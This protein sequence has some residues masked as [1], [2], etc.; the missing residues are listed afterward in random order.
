MSALPGVLLLVVLTL[1]VAASADTLRVGECAFTVTPLA[2]D[3]FA[4]GL[5]RWMVEGNSRVAT[6][7]G[8]L[9]IETPEQGYA[10]VWYRQP[11]S[12]DLLIRF[13]ARVLPPR[14]ASNI[15]F[16]CYA[17]LPEGGGFFAPPRT[18]AYAEYHRINNYTMTFTGRREGVASAPGYLRLRKNPGFHLVDE[19]LEVKAEIETDYAI[20]LAKVGPLI[21]VF[22]NDRQV[23]SFSD[24]NAAGERQDYRAGYVGFRTFWSRLTC[25]D[26]EVWRIEAAR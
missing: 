21:R 3:D 9:C 25:D 8:R 19:N 4:G 26:F 15:N 24:V 13:R 14:Q 5:D 10:T 7:D 12:G 20:A 17:S 6:R 16:F 1:A 22:V 18:G 23:L 11:F 2:A